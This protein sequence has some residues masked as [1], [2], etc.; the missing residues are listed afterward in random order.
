MTK[1]SFYF[2]SVSN[3]LV[4]IVYFHW[5]TKGKLYFVMY[6][7]NWQREMSTYKYNKYS[8]SFYI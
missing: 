3:T 1:V 2:I 5:N 6:I 4:S 8:F 7:V